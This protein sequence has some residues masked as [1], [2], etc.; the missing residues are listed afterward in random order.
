MAQSRKDK[1]EN[2]KSGSNSKSKLKSK[3]KKWLKNI[4]C[5]NC[6]KK[7]HYAIDC[8]APKAENSNNVPVR[9]VDNMGAHAVK[10]NLGKGKSLSKTP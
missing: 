9:S 10:S 5:F 3:D 8:Q 4:E 2:P 7:G 6:H 1:K